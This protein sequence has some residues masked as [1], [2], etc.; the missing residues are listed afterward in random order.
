[1]QYLSQLT[2][3]PATRQL[4]QQAEDQRIREAQAAEATE[5]ANLKEERKEKARAKRLL[6]QTTNVAPDLEKGST[7]SVST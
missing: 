6:S 5:L 3:L 2:F 7:T 1:M 4:E